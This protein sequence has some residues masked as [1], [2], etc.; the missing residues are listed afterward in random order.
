M[1]PKVTRPKWWFHGL[2]LAVLLATV[3]AFGQDSGASTLE[4]GIRLFRTGQ[5]E[6]AR[7][8]FE[9]AHERQPSDTEAAFYLGRVAFERED[10]ETAID[11]FAQAADGE[12]CP[13]EAYLW[14]GRAYGYHAQRSSLLHKPLL[15]RKTHAHL[16][17]AVACAPDHVAAHWDLMEYYA[18]APIFLG[19]S[20]KK[21]GEQANIIARL[22]PAEGRKARQFLAEMDG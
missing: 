9:A 21:A 10:F 1:G 8:I 5:L 13:A 16:E 12:G 17:Q 19:G 15:A 3:A 4:D 2:G 7:R 20:R 6:D 11:W 14:L 22:D 18:K